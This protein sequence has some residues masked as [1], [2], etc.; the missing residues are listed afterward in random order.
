V[1]DNTVINNGSRNSYM[2]G[3]F[4]YK[5]GGNGIFKN[6][7]YWHLNLQNKIFKYS[8][9]IWKIEAIAIKVGLM[10]LSSILD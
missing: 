10:H 1:S 2:K 6:K 9:Q 5:E 7:V 8:L 3:I 4:F